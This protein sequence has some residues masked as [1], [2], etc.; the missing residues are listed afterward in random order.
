LTEG[1]GTWHIIMTD[2]PAVIAIV[3]MAGP[4]L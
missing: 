1:I 2:N 3:P 4:V